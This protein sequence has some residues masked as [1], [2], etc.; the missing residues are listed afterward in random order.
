MEIPAKKLAADRN[1]RER[2]SEYFIRVEDTCFYRN[3]KLGKAV[4]LKFYV[5]CI[6][7]LSPRALTLGRTRALQSVFLGS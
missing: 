3:L 4:G 7:R 5:P 2:Y 1:I 6:L